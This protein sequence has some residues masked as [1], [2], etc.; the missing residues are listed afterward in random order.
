MQVDLILINLQGLDII[1]GM[2]FLAKHHAS[3]DCFHKEVTFKMPGLPEVVFQGDCRPS[4][5]GLISSFTTHRLLRKGCVGF[6]AYI[7][8][9]H[10]EEV[11]LEDIPVVRDFSDVFPDDLPGLPPERDIEFAIDLVP[12]TTPIS[13]P[14]YRWLK[15]N[16]R[17]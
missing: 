6:L 3:M 11:R 13:L 4:R 12:G 7:V 1:F 9:T 5:V 15:L 16:L 2:D 14:P 17:N 8:D 10:V